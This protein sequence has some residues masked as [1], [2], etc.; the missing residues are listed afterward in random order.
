MA[1]HPMPAT[2]SIRELQ[3]S[4]RAILD[5]LK[6]SRGSALLLNHRIPEAVLLDVETYNALVGDD[7]AYDEVTTAKL[8]AAAR[9]S[10]RKGKA[11]KLRSWSDLDR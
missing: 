2:Y 10:Y 11:K 9:A 8:V 5:T 7:Y 3:R 1:L 4:Y 6:R